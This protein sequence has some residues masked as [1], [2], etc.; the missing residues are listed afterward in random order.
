MR[1]DEVLGSMR[2][3]N[4]KHNMQG[5][6]WKAP[7]ARDSPLRPGIKMGSRRQRMIREGHNYRLG[8]R[9]AIT[10]G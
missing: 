3:G 10:R 5:A 8:M 6:T 7:R 1:V 9:G 2:Q 4:G